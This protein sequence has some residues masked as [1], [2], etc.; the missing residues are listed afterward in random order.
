MISH[1]DSGDLWRWWKRNLPPW[2]SSPSPP[3]TSNHEKNIRQI[4][5]GEH[6]T[7]SPRS[8]SKLSRSSPSR[9]VWETVTAERS[10]RRPDNWTWCGLLDGIFQQKMNEVKSSEIWMIYNHQLIIGINIRSLFLINAIV[11]R[12][13]SRVR[14]FAVPWTIS[15]QIHLSPITSQSLLRFMSTESVMPSSHLIPC[16]PL[17]LLPST[18]PSI[19]VFSNESVLRIRWP[20]Y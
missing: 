1:A 4:L 13:L 9:R 2:P 8:S 16:R 10:L 15:R 18:F 11:I 6:P 3:S 17:L 7:V 5:I 20:K 19:R 14:L 12:S